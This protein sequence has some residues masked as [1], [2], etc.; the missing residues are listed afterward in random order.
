LPT[1]DF[2]HEIGLLEI[3]TDASGLIVSIDAEL[4]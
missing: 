4:E 3:R 1:G 2:D